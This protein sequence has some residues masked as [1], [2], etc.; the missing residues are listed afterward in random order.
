[1]CP[2]D[3]PI[4]SHLTGVKNGCAQRSCPS[5]A[6]RGPPAG[7]V[8]CRADTCR[9]DWYALIISPYHHSR[10]GGYLPRVPAH[11]ISSDAPMLVS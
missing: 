7:G 1:M 2:A 6:P 8:A 9:H 11:T 10:Q 4:L 5:V 3:V